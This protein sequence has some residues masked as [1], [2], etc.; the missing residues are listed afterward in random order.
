MSQWSWN[1]EHT[2]ALGI[3][4]T[5]ELEREGF[6]RDIIRHIQEIR[7]RMG[8][9]MMECVEV[10]YATEDPVLLA[11]I[12]EFGDT[13]RAETRASRLELGYAHGMKEVKLSGRDLRL[14]LFAPDTEKT[15]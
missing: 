12:A 5:P 1:K 7:K 10:S 15:P 14:S 6:A 8:L 11:A 13:I 3:E 4:L 2:L 9:E